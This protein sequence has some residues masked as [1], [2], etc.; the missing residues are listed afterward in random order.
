MPALLEACLQVHPLL[1]PFLLVQAPLWIIR[2]V[3]RGVGVHDPH[4]VDIVYPLLSE[5]T[6]QQAALLFCDL[7]RRHFCVVCVSVSPG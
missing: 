6:D 2:P 1:S 4:V 3:Y 7:W 5:V